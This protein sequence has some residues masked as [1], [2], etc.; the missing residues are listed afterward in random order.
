[1]NGNYSNNDGITCCVCILKDKNTEAFRVIYTLN[2]QRYM[3]K[4]DNSTL[5]LVYFR[6]FRDLLDGIGHKL[7]LEQLSVKSIKRFVMI[8]KQNELD[9]L[10]AES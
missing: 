3:Q 10:N 1:M 8:N 5:K 9:E 2:I 6:G 7:F 4:Q